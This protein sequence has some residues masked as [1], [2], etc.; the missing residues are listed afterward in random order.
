MTIDKKQSINIKHHLSVTATVFVFQQNI[1][2]ATLPVSNII[3]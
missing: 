2:R 1:P 3:T